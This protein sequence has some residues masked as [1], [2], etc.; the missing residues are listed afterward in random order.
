MR[1]YHKPD[2]DETL[3]HNTDETLLHARH[4]RDVI[5]RPTPTRHY[6]TPDATPDAYVSVGRSHISE[7]EATV[8]QGLTHLGTEL[9][10]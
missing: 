7:D 10:P 1:L 2:N 3:I 4:E 9:G 8:C 6:Y 5:T